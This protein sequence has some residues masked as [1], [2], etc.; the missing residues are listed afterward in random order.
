MLAGGGARGAYEVGALSVLLPELEARGERPTVLVG[1]SVGA[2]N[3]AFLAATAQ[4]TAEETS[5]R[6][7][8]YW[9]EVTKG[10]VVRPI[11]RRTVPVTLARYIGEILSIPG[12]RFA[13]LLDPTPLRGNLARWIEPK[14]LRENIDAGAVQALA[15]IATTVRTGRTV[16][17]VDARPKRKMHRSHAIDYVSAHISIDHL[18]ASAAI[19][20]LFPPVR[21]DEPA[22][23]RGWYMDGGT[24]LNT[25]IK[26]ALDLGVDRLVVVGTDSIEEPS[27]DSGRHDAA[28]PDMGDAGLHLLHGRLVDPLVEDLR[29]LGNVNL[30]FGDGGASPAADRFR[31]ARGKPPYRTVPYIFVGPLKRGAVGDLAIE[32]FRNR[33]GGLK[34][35]RSPDFPA[36]SRLLG[37]ESPSHGELLSYLLF[38]HEFIEELIAMG[39]RDA[40]SWLDASPA[41]DPWRIEPLEAFTRAST[42]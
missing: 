13:G 16:A 35:L 2:I 20:L 29:Q 27:R 32:V 15:V 23:A 12:V 7:I 38:D 5:A 10:Q 28:A 42:P 26:P 36:L 21:I 33:Y 39:K 9:Q 24:R 34:G 30:F 19:P 18:R 4:L 31:A 41:K 8:A 11:L 6:G 22:G 1:T 37:G 40:R 25:P 14:A 17:F 3:A